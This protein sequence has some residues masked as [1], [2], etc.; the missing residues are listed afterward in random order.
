MIRFSSVIVLLT[1]ASSACADV[2]DPQLK[3]D[4]PWYPGELACSTWDRLFAT[5]VVGRRNGAEIDQWLRFGIGSSAS[6]GNACCYRSTKL[7][8][9]QFLPFPLTSMRR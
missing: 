2:G 8:E 4:H 1:F 6:V 3:T 9:V 5:Q 7:T